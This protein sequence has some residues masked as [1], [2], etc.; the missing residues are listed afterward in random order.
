MHLTS[1]VTLHNLS[2]Q[3]ISPVK[4]PTFNLSVQLASQV[5]QCNLSVQ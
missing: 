1:Q 4:L 3:Y 5:T 2:V